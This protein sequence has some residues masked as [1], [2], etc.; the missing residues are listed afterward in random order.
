[1]E[2][3]S[4]LNCEKLHAYTNYKTDLPYTLVLIPCVTP[5][6]LGSASFSIYKHKRLKSK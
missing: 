4:F 2:L 1:M 6:L 5:L 3:A